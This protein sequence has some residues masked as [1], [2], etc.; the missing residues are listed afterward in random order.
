MVLVEALETLTLSL[1]R[2]DWYCTFVCGCLKENIWT[3]GTDKKE[4]NLFF[5]VRDGRERNEWSIL[6]S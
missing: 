2:F 4:G 1:S 5:R 6:R 3:F